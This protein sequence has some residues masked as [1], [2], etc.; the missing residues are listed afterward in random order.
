MTT[1]SGLLI[2]F[3]IEPPFTTCSIGH[4]SAHAGTLDQA[5]NICANVPMI[6]VMRFQARVAD[7]V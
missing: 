2:N 6:S 1:S 3:F 4:N 5:P 7:R